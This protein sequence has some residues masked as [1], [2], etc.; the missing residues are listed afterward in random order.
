MEWHL[1]IAALYQEQC[2]QLCTI[3]SASPLVIRIDQATNREE[4]YYKLENIPV[5]FVVIHQ[6]LI[7]DISLLPEGHFV[8]LAQKRNE[9]I[10]VAACRHGGHYFL[11][12]PL[13]IAMLLYSQ[14]R[15]SEVLLIE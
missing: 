7:T 11:D 5:N 13:P 1:L 15:Q 8:I 14:R 4:L 9:D 2:E 6:P 12:N 3:Y 10:L